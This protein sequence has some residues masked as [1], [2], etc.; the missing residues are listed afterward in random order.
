MRQPAN[1]IRDKRWAVDRSAHPAAHPPVP[2]GR[3]SLKGESA[4]ASRSR[5]SG[6]CRPTVWAAR[7]TVVG[8][9]TGH[10]MMGRNGGKSSS[11]EERESENART[12]F[13]IARSAN[14]RAKT[15]SGDAIEITTTCRTTRATSDFRGRCPSAKLPLGEGAQL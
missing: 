6:L 5:G 2:A 11:R 4:R 12:E 8:I 9:R 15:S 14:A 3:P 7:L 1:R 13:E 10:P